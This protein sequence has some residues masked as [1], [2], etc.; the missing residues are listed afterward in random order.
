MLQFSPENSKTKKLRNKGYLLK[1]LKDGRKIYSLDLLS[2]W[3]CPFAKACKSKV[4]IKQGRKRIQDGKDCEFRCFSA[5]TEA[6]Y[7][8]VYSIRKGNWR[9]LVDTKTKRGITQLLQASLPENAGIIRYHVAGDFFKCAYFEA[10]L[11]LARKRPDILFYAYTKAIGYWVKNIDKIP[12]NFVLTASVGGIFDETIKTF[13]L[14]S[15]TVVK[16]KAEAKKLGLP[17]DND[18]SHAANPNRKQQSFALLVHGVQPKG[19]YSEGE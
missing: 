14:R 19:F 12:D 1:Y 2:G 15:A 13:G 11:E 5:S 3:S 6:L 18:D 9:K 10:A 16:T 17:L 8:G 7:P 4:I